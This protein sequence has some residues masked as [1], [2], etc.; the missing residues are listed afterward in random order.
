VKKKLIYKLRFIFWL[1][2]KKGYKKFVKE[3]G[4]EFYRSLLSDF[5]NFDFNIE[6]KKFSTLIY[7]N[8]SHKNKILTQYI[9]QKYMHDLFFFSYFFF[10][11]KNKKIIVPIPKEI[12]YFFK[13]KKIPINFFIS[14]LFW[15]F[16][17]I[18]EILK[19]IK[20]ILFLVIRTFRIDQTNFIQSDY[21]II[22][23]IGNK[24]L[25]LPDN[26]IINKKLFNLINWC[27][28][29]F[30]ENNFVLFDKIKIKRDYYETFLNIE[31]LF[32]YKLSKYKVLF[33]LFKCLIFIIKE[34]LLLR[35]HNLILLSESVKAFYV[36]CS[37]QK[38]PRNTFFI[39]TNNCYR[40]LW[41]YEIESKKSNVK[42]L[43]VGLLNGLILP[44]QKKLTSNDW[45]G[46]S[47]CTWPI[48]YVWN[49]QH[50][51]YIEDKILIKSNFYILKEPTYLKDSNTTLSLPKNTI[52][53]FAYENNKQCLGCA[54]LADY[55]V[56][57][58]NLLRSFYFDILSCLKKNNYFGVIKRKRHLSDSLELKKN[59]KIFTDLQ[60]DNNVIL[61]DQD[62]SVEKVINITKASISLPFTSPGYISK[63]MGKKSIFYDPCKWININDPSR[64]G[65]KIV[66]SRSQLDNWIKDL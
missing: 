56:E 27:T 5:A 18:L 9:F 23:N 7:R 14:N 53:L 64:V 8:Y 44:G 30:Y 60:K 32:S 26:K 45:E 50:K 36:I 3:N 48:Y 24:K 19:G 33:F 15:Y 25:N 11:N 65:I 12:N 20:N 10:L 1:N 41:S 51:K 4:L 29:K 35:W 58:N 22:A 55:D 43:F 63:S 59:K 34:L 46:L 66:N 17:V 62:H 52:A 2:V 31:E 57:N 16:I 42:M 13:K 21:S 61:I 54:T 39:W 6:E 28:K 49:D 37:V 38:I 40:P 47:I